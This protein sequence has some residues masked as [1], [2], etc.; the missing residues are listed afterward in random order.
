[1]SNVENEFKKKLKDIITNAINNFNCKEVYLI[2]NDLS[3][4]C[5]CARF[6]M[7]LT[8]VLQDTEYSEYIV[9]V[10]YNRGADG[11]ERSTKRLDDRC[12]TVDLIVH[13]RGCDATYGFDNLIC[14]EMKKSTDRRGCES[15]EL[16]L[17]NMID[18]KFGF[19]YKT[20]FMILI[21]MQKCI[22]EIK[23]QY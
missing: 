18:P 15:D 3:E 21:N 12:I 19:C 4:R 5:I 10:E 9:D 11:T 22:L 16:R 6:A 17:K 8:T 1:M 14:A 20:G 13:K 23:E 7:H 2:K